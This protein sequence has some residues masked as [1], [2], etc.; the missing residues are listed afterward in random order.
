M[1][2]ASP[3]LCGQSGLPRSCIACAY[4][5][6]IF[7]SADLTCNQIAQKDVQGQREYVILFNQSFRHSVLL[8]YICSS[9]DHFNWIRLPT[10]LS[11]HCFTLWFGLSLFTSNCASDSSPMGSGVRASSVRNSL[12]SASL[13]AISSAISTVSPGAAREEGKREGMK[14]MY[15]CATAA[16]KLLQSGNKRYS[17]GVW[18]RRTTHFRTKKAKK[19]DL[20]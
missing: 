10:A 18:G 6:S 2:Y 17:S 20:K 16:E 9:I 4:A 13:A 8:L 15:A 12:R 7:L 19:E 5:P 3:R 11:L 14:Y 1:H